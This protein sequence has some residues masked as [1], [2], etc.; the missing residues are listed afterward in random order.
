MKNRKKDI[1]HFGVQM[2]NGLAF[3]TTWFLIL[4]LIICYTFNQQTISVNSLAKMLILIFGGVFIFNLLFTR[5]LIKKWS[6]TRR[7]TI[8]MLSISVYECAGFYWLGFFRGKGTFVQWI[9]FVGI[10]CGLYFCCVV[11]YRNYSKK[12]G[13]IYTQALKK[14]QQERNIEE[15]I[16]P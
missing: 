3:C 16:F 13:E 1:I 8:F 7:L 5:I 6:F 12:Q 10:V 15:E 14:Y 9:L 4:V 2:R 11:I